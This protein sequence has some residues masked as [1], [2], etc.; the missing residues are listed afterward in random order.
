M[1]HHFLPVSLDV[2]IVKHSTSG[3][4]LSEMHWQM[5]GQQLGFGWANTV[6]FSPVVLATLLPQKTLLSGLQCICLC[7]VDIKNPVHQ[8]RKKDDC[9]KGK[10]F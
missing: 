2:R 6:L 7:E 10:T 5:L 9:H 1:C 3:K 4:S 8:K